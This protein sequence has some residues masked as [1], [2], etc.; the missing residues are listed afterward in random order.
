[1]LILE[2]KMP[3]KDHMP[4]TLPGAAM[5]ELFHRPG[6]S[7]PCVQ[8]DNAVCV[9]SP[10]QPRSHL[11]GS[12]EGRSRPEPLPRNSLPFLSWASRE[13]VGKGQ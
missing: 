7:C 10:Y 2:Q 4:I 11:K 12:T 6:C 3:Q 1:M 13:T 9:R 8:A 5:T